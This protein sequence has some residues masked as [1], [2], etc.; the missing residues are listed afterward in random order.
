MLAVH[1]DPDRRA[2]LGP[3]ADLVAG[4]CNVK[5]LRLAESADEITTIEVVPDFGR[6]GPKFRADAPRIAAL[7]RAGQFRRKGSRYLVGS[8][9]LDTRDVLVRTR[10][11]PGFAVAEQ[12]GWVVALDTQVT[13][14][15]ELEGRARDLVRQI[16][17]LRK[18]A[19]LEV[20]NRIDVV[21]PAGE[22]DVVDAF[23]QWI[24]DQTLAESL[25][26]GRR[27][28]VTAAAG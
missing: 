4:E 26:A 23:G 19:G 15:L 27:L 22:A 3:L 9:V 1:A 18:D 21:F 17:Q 25:A 14:E 5:R 10:A 11:R 16:Q 8:W 24:A 13:R 6:L 12:D 7:L 2:A 28:R 20:T